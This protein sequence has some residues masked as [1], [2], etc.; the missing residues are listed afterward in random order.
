MRTKHLVSVLVALLSWVG[1]C[2][3]VERSNAALERALGEIDARAIEADL[4]FIA[5][6]EL[7]GRDTPSHGLQ[8][9]ARYLRSRLERLGF[10]PGGDHGFFDE[11]RLVT[12]D[13]DVGASFVSIERGGAEQ[14][15]AFGKGYTFWSSG[16][17]DQDLA[18]GVVFVGKGSAAEVE[19]RDLAGKWALA[20]SSREVSWRERP[21]NARAAG[22]LGLIVAPD[23]SESDERAGR[24][25]SSEPRRVRVEG[26]DGDEPAF[27]QLWLDREG[28]R[29]LFGG[30][31]LP[32]AGNELGIR[33]RDKRVVVPGTVEV[34]EN[35]AGL[36]PG[37]DP[38]LGR[39][40]IV[41]SAHYDHEGVHEGLVYNGADDNG[42]GTCALLAVADA[43][44]QYGPMRRSV[45]LLWVS[46]EEKGLW[47]S[48]A[49][50]KNPTLPE[51]TRAVCD[52][53]VDMVGR[54]APDKLLITPTKEHEEYNGLTRLAESLAPLEGFPALGSCDD[55]WDRS[56]HASFAENLG[57][58]V[59]FLFS[60]VHEDYHQPSDDVEKIDYDKIR[61]VT[62]LL[63]RMLDGLQADVLAL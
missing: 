25:R 52:L 56:D 29:A 38:V 16:I 8:L 43:L 50:T 18:G 63:V 55:Y 39:E 19:G 17:V 60:D 47:G 49:W 57:L 35:V 44:A 23:P 48:S 21:R 30:A 13:L 27:P 32:A 51:G 2:G 31:A 40:V 24:I 59:A 34:V 5:S 42:S 3:G 37:S 58:P 11:Y 41:L 33:V 14:R 28:G 45:L 9:A 62:R 26:S 7:Q 4:R 20:I 46:G 1:L 61:R 6:D 54:N 36:W 12:T 22:A 15:L 53:N 10:T